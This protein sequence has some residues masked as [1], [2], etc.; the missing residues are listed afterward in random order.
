[1]KSNRGFILLFAM[2]IVLLIVPRASAQSVENTVHNLSAS[3]P[4]QVKASSESEVCLFCHTPHQASAQAPLWNRP[5]PGATYTLYSSSTADASPG[6]PD[7]SSVLCLSCHDGTI[8]LGSVLSRGSDISFSGGVTTMPAGT[9]NLTTDLSDDHP[10]SFTYNSS[11]A[12]ADGELADPSSLG[13]GV[14]LENG[15]VQCTS[16][17]DPHNNDLGDFLV[18]SNRNSAL[19]LHCHEKDQW[20]SGSHSNSSASWNGT[21]ADPWFHTPYTTVSE[22]GCENC[23]NPHNAEGGE[24]LLNSSMEE[25]NC[26]ICHSGNVAGADIEAM[27]TRPYSHD[28]FAYAQVHD[29]NESA[30]VQVQHVECTDCHNPHAA[31]TGTASAPVANGFLAG[32]RGVD[33]DG[34]GVYPIQFE[35]EL[36]YRCHADSPD[37]PAGAV[38][39]FID[40]NN[41]R[42]EF[43]QTN[44]SY[45]PIEG[46]GRNSN[47]RSLIAPLSES[48]V[49]YCTSC[50]ASDGS[51]SPTGPHGSIYPHILKYQYETA[52][53]TQESFQSYELCYQCHDRNEITNG[54]SK[55]AKNVHRRHIMQVRV[56][57]SIC[58]DPHGISA[59]QG[60]SVN[61]AHLINFDLSVVSP[62]PQSGRLEFVDLGDYSG[63]CY[64]KCHNKRHGPKNY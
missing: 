19:C 52:D 48:S 5:D 26:L 9:T 23:H 35:Y 32:V 1:M 51:G 58:H 27:L 37:K 30:V 12:A 16:C 46:P 11:L 53:G 47:V 6:Q 56:A 25:T 22:N 36:C 50:H 7:G 2:V 42:L 63:A 20:S 40:Q 3:G 43:E 29:P 45:H 61:H 31:R 24:R 54:S 62:D 64:L 15:S 10:V 8:A 17:H 38:N 33:T 4:G 49:I 34:N 59:S 60:N 14:S 57:C 13:G 55:F 18:D 39:R 44:P 28:V 21:G 41:V